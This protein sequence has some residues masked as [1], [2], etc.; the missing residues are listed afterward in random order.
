MMDREG[1]GRRVGC[2][3]IT[4]NDK[5]GEKGREGREAFH[6]DL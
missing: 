2:V 5:K 4:G 1:K 3:V 6:D